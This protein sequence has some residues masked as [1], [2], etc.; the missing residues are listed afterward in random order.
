MTERNQYLPKAI[1][2]IPMTTLRTAI[3]PKAAIVQFFKR[4]HTNSTRSDTGHKDTH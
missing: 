1:V 4:G 2:N 3:I